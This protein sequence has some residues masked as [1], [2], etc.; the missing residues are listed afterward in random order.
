MRKVLKVA[1]LSFVLISMMASSFSL[2][3]VGG[4]YTGFAKG[5]GVGAMIDLP[6]IPFIPT[7]L[8][9]TSVGDVDVVANLTYGGQSFTGTKKFSSLALDFQAKLP[10]VNIAGVDVGA[11]LLF[12]LLTGKADNGTSVALPGGVYAGIFGQMNQNLLPLVDGFMQ[13]GYLV[14]IVDA[15]KALADGATGVGTLDM[16]AADR[17]GLFYR[18]GVSIGI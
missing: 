2:F 12:D 10:F 7:V 17:S 13:L 15:Q 6:I 18:I 4:T 8:S 14:K 5:S 11:D 16:S 3:K 1:M 9:V